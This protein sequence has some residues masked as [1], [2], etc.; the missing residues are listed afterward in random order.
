MN[1]GANCVLEICCPPGSAAPRQTLAAEVSKS[2]GYDLEM[3]QQVAEFI[4]D[5]YDLAPKGSLG[6][7]KA[8]VARLARQGYVKG[9]G[10]V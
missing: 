10:S 7:L 9:D 1:G 3:C 8:E 6:N 4:F 2:T 5:N